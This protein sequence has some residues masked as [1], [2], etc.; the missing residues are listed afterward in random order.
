MDSFSQMKTSETQSEL[1]QR[2]MMMSTE[3]MGTIEGIPPGSVADMS[4]GTMNSSTFSLFGGKGNDSS[5][6]A[7]WSGSGSSGSGSNGQQQLPKPSY[8]DIKSDPSLTSS[9]LTVL[10]GASAMRH[11]ILE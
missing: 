5:N 1:E 11:I 8:L 3:T 10:S 7:G 6:M 4:I 2:R 9:G